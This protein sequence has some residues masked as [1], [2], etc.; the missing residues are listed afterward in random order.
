MRL[1]NLIWSGCALFAAALLTSAAEPAQPEEKFDVS[2]FL[3]RYYQEPAP[4]RIPEF[5]SALQELGLAEKPNARPP[6]TGFLGEII[7]ANPGQVADWSR[8][9][10]AEAKALQTLWDDAVKMAGLGG[11][12][13]VTAHSPATNDMNWGAFFATGN[14]EF[15][16]W[17]IREASHLDEREDRNLFLT[18]STACWSLASNARAHPRVRQVVEAAKA[19]ASPRGR[20]ILDEIL[21]RDPNHYR[22]EMT[23]IIRQQRKQG[24]WL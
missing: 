23:G 18:G 12:R 22:T 17:I 15:V 9:I 11:V 21:T 1:R 13:S 5:L 20:E 10:P 7:R 16:Q 4:A 14:A 3:E 2:N 8:L 24:K 19:S 6:L